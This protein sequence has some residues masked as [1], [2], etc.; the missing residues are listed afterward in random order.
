MQHCLAL[1]SSLTSGRERRRETMMTEW[2][3]ERWRPRINVLLLR[4]SGRFNPKRCYFERTTEYTGA[5]HAMTLVWRSLFPRQVDGRGHL[6]R[7]GVPFPIVPS[8]VNLSNP[9]NTVCTTQSTAISLIPHLLGG[10]AVLKA[11]VA[12]AAVAVAGVSAWRCRMG[13]NGCH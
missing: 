5:E 1:L 6:P 13:A 8:S 12:G 7:V 2:M 10:L 3:S 4:G 11:A 9:E